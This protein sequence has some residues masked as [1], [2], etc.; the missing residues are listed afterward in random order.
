MCPFIE[1]PSTYEF[2]GG[3]LFFVH[4]KWL[5]SC[6]QRMVHVP[7]RTWRIK[8]Q[9]RKKHETDRSL[10]V[11]AWIEFGFLHG[12]WYR[13]C[14]WNMTGPNVLD[15]SVAIGWKRLFLV[16]LINR[17]TRNL[18]AAWTRLFS[19]FP[20]KRRRRRTKK[21]RTQSNGVKCTSQESMQSTICAV[22]Q[23]DSLCSPVNGCNAP[24]SIFQFPKSIWSRTKWNPWQLQQTPCAR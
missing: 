3:F 23:T 6:T 11:F 20:M 14:N 17:A 2:G 18:S 16:H 13:V 7:W 22:E 1:S 10:L 15:F 12:V 8:G 21:N 19:Y 4:Y 24:N 9:K 5:V